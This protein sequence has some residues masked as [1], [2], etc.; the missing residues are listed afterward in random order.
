MKVLLG[1]F[2]QDHGTVQTSPDGLVFAGPDPEHV[3]ELVERRRA[4]YDR[5]GVEHMLTDD[6]LVRSL[7]Y[8][9]HGQFTWAVV[10]DEVTG[11]TEDQPAYDP[12]GK[13]WSRPASS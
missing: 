12:W 2:N 13:M 6:E 11:L 7:P 4:W 9:L 1:V 10:V 5:V 3:R 8:R